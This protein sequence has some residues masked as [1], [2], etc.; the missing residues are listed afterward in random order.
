VNGAAMDVL[1]NAVGFLGEDG[2]DSG[3]T[4]TE[5]KK[6]SCDDC[7]KKVGLVLGVE[8]LGTK[9]GASLKQAIGTCAGS[10]KG[11]LA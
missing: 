6:L 2:V 7:H 4:G 3:G 11:D 8:R 1:P 10:F 5:I 9:T